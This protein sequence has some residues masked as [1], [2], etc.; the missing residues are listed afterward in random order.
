MPHSARAH[1]CPD[2]GGRCICKQETLKAR[3][4]HWSHLGEGKG[5]NK[6]RKGGEQARKQV[7]TGGRVSIATNGR[8]WKRCLDDLG[9]RSTK[10]MCGKL[11]HV[12]CGIIPPQ[13]T[14]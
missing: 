14:P 3:K 13:L 10:S 12:I 5:K 7:G 8:F 6:V 2:Q 9:E 11:C 1:G 4:E